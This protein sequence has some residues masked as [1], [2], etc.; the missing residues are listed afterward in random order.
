MSFRT[1]FY[2]VQIFKL[3]LLICAM[4]HTKP[5]PAKDEVKMRKRPRRI[6]M[7]IWG[8]IAAPI[9]LFTT[10]T[11]IASCCGLHKIGKLQSAADSNTDPSKAK[12]RKIRVLHKLGL[13]RTCCCCDCCCCDNCKVSQQDVDQAYKDIEAMEAQPRLPESQGCCR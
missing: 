8:W 6:R 1:R 3:S 9:A 11:C 4:P 2:I 10:I 7:P 5:T 12:S 13:F